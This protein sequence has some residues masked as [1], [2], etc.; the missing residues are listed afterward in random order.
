MLALFAA[1]S[2]TPLPFPRLHP[3]ASHLRM[4]QNDTSGVV[5]SE[6]KSVG[7]VC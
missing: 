1:S 7:F 4:D 3:V 5:R 2:R 6:W